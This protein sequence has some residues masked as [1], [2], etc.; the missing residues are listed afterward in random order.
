MLL[1]HCQPLRIALDGWAHFEKKETERDASGVY[2]F[3]DVPGTGYRE[4]LETVS[5]DSSLQ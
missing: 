2:V 5:R 4:T 1:T 3:R